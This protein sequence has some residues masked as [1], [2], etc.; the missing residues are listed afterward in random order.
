M[1]F[2]KLAQLSAVVTLAITGLTGTPA[3]ASEAF[4]IS[5]SQTSRLYDGQIVSI[6]TSNLPSDKGIYVLQCLLKD[7]KPDYPTNCTSLKTT[8]QSVLWISAAPG[9]SSQGAS[10]PAIANNFKTIRTVNGN[11][12]ATLSCAIVTVRDHMGS[13]DRTFDT[14]TAL[15]FSTVIPTISKVKDL[16]DAG[17]TISITL[18]GLVAG[19]G[20]Y[21]RLCQLPTGITNPP[22]AICDGQG[23]WASTSS[24]WITYGATDASKPFNL[25]VKGLFVSDGKTVDCQLTSCGVFIRRDHLA[26]ADRTLDTFVP[27]QFAPPVKVAQTVTK[28]NKNPGNYTLKLNSLL[29]VTTGKVTTNR[30]TSLTWKSSNP[31]VCKIVAKGNVQQIVPVKVGQ[32]VVTASAAEN[33]RLLPATFNWTVKVVR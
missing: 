13:S 22:T 23:V 7:G 24:Q 11:D 8:P 12:C 20:A 28:W 3:V 5:I 10:N 25:N 16:I 9:S 30:G 4:G 14:A 32:C 27:L 17:E 29:S 2:Q 6:V 1:R 21:A 19:S 26:S 31:S 18:S 15:S 33:S